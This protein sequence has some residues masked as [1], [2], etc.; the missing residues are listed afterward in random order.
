[1]NKT[2]NSNNFDNEQATLRDI[3]LEF[4]EKGLVIIQVPSESEKTSL[5]IKLTQNNKFMDEAYGNM[6]NI[7]YLSQD[8]ELIDSMSIFDNLIITLNDNSKI[9][10]LLKKYNLYNLRHI[11]INKCTLLQKKQ[12]QFIK[13]LLLNP[14]IL[15][16]DE[17]L[18]SLDYENAMDLMEV[19]QDS[20]KFFLVIAVMKDSTL[21]NKYADRIIEINKDAITSDVLINKCS[22]LEFTNNL[23]QKKFFDTLLAVKRHLF[24]KP[25]RFLLNLSL[26][27]L[28]SL[29]AYLQFNILSS[30]NSNVDNLIL[31][32]GNQLEIRIKGEDASLYTKYY[33]KF[34]LLFFKDIQETLI[35]NPEIM[36]YAP[37]YSSQY[38]E[39]VNDKLMSSLPNNDIYKKF[40]ILENE[41]E[42][43]N[44]ISLGNRP[45]DGPIVVYDDIKNWTV[46][47][48]NDNLITNKVVAFN[49]INNNQKLP[50]IIGTYPKNS[51]D[52]IIDK[53]IAEHLLQT[54][55]LQNYDE[56]LNENIE[57]GVKSL[58]NVYSM[59]VDDIPIIDIHT[60]TICGVTSIQNSFTNM[61]FMTDDIKNNFLYNTYIDNFDDVFF[62]FNHLLIDPSFNAQKIANKINDQGDYVNTSYSVYQGIDSNGNVI[63]YKTP[64]DIL[65][66]NIIFTVLCL[67]ILIILNFSQRKQL[68]KEN[69]NIVYLKYSKSIY[70]FMQILIYLF[71]SVSIC[72]ILFPSLV[73]RINEFATKNNYIKF[74]TFNPCIIGLVC[75]ISSLIYGL[76][77][78]LLTKTKGK[79]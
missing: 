8:I 45:L 6:H 13:S 78:Y 31:S 60:F 57:L 74:M 70:Q 17:P 66:Y 23:P 3:K 20:S 76:I 40:I 19:I 73:E 47:D 34:D 77:Y 71:L 22:N 69:K 35:N 52:I 2:V 68:L 38:S 4:N 48:L 1:M 36:A 59:Y 49:L 14:N 50:L 10:L 65:V 15:L 41:S 7:I 62:Q 56:L 11:K 67:L 32:S 72:L 12:I 46:R 51:T 24:S 29:F 63:N 61:V 39:K 21:A 26:I 53:D 25:F 54:K 28:I 5:L 75:L 37:Y 18:S 58:Q 33:R 42:I 30:M 9:E 43:I 16:C 79:A 27:M 64:K 44:E 55:N